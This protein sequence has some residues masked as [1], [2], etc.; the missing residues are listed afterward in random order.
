MQQMQKE[1]CIEIFGA[2]RTLFDVDGRAPITDPLLSVAG[3][4]GRSR[5]TECVFG[6]VTTIY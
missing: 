1:R 3:A 5:L 4:Y 6:C 2:A